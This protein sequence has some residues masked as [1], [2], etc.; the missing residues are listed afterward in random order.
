VVLPA[1]TRL[2]GFGKG[3]A[4]LVRTDEDGLEWLGRYRR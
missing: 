1:D 3:V 4:Y 2:V